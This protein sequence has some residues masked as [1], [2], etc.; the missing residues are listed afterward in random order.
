MG[1]RNMETRIG[2]V[3]GDFEDVELTCPRCGSNQVIVETN[4]NGF[5]EVVE[6]HK[7]EY[8]KAAI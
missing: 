6:C 3:P 5:F 8:R 1:I 4:N 2:N 7:C